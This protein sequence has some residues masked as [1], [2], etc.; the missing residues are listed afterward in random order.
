MKRNCQLAAVSSHLPN[1][2][3]WLLLQKH[4]DLD[5]RYF[6]AEGLLRCYKTEKLRVANG[7]VSNRLK[8]FLLIREI[9][10][11]GLGTSLLPPVVI[12]SSIK[13]ISSSYLFKYGFSS[14]L[15]KKIL[16]FQQ[17]NQIVSG[18]E[19]INDAAE[20]S[21]QFDSDYNEILP[22]TTK[23]ILGRID[24]LHVTSSRC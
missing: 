18:L 3:I 10:G 19:V 7:T 17:I 13:P 14:I 9:M 22:T 15:E 2:K 21:V 23:H 24:G 8:H 6:S 16:L 11:K 1:L 20:R 5:Y 4:G 12:I